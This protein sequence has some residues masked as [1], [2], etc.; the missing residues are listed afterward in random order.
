MIELAH[1][2]GSSG[3]AEQ[4]LVAGPC[5]LSAKAAQPMMPTAKNTMLHANVAAQTVLLTETSFCYHE[6]AT[7]QVRSNG[8]WR[9]HTLVQARG[10]ARMRV[11]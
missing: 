6:H 8:N 11:R 3:K 1:C 5:S 2:D 9:E 10:G 4:A 7:T